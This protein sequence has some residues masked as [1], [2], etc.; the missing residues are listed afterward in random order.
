MTGFSV[1]RYVFGKG[2]DKELIAFQLHFWDSN[3]D[4]QGLSWAQHS[5]E[6]VFLLQQGFFFPRKS[7]QPLVQSYSPKNK[8]DFKIRFYAFGS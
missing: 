4:Q 7:F 6:G 5:S 3:Q 1:F 2:P 8:V